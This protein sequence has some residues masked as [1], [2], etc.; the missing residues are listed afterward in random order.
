M[1]IS[2]KF[3]YFLNSF[4]LTLFSSLRVSFFWILIVIRNNRFVKPAVIIKN[5]GKKM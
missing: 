4:L 5:T 1:A 2:V 3:N